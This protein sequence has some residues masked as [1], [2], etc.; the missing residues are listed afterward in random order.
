V[1]QAAPQLP[2]DAVSEIAK[3]SPL[4]GE[5]SHAFVERIW[6][7]F[8]S[9]RLTLGLLALLGLGL[10]LGHFV[11][12]AGDALP[13]LERAHA[14]RQFVLWTFR[15]FELYDVSRSWWFSLLWAALGLNFVASSLE[16]L[17]RIHHLL[18][19]PPLRLEEVPGLPLRSAE[20]KTQRTEAELRGALEK[21]GYAV[22]Q[23]ARDDGADLFAEKGRS[24]RWGLWVIHLAFLIAL[25][26]ALVNRF[27][28]FEGTAL[29][30]GN[31][32]RANSMVIR[33]RDGSELTRNL[34]LVVQCDDFRL[35]DATPGKPGASQSDLRLLSG[36]PGSEN[37][38]LAQKTISANDPLE[39]GGLTFQQATFEQLE[40]GSRAQVALV[41]KVTGRE[42][43][44]KLGAGESLEAAEGLTFRLVDYQE[45]FVGMGPAVQVMRVEE[46]PGALVNK[47]AGP[48]RVPSAQAKLSSFWIFANKPDFDRDNRTD[49]FALKFGKVAPLY[50]TGLRIS[51]DPS[52]P[53]LYAGGALLVAGLVLSFSTSHKRIWARLH[54]GRVAIG[55][56]AHR[57]QEAFSRELEKI[58]TAL[59]VEIE[60]KRPAPDGSTA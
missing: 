16:R 34:G 27:A 28:A 48:R 11:N 25:L 22:T 36:E 53:L 58:C 15:T 50:A 6:R 21:A 12:P 37:R 57:N 8:T 23:A 49:R 24:A 59:G 5:Q 1:T 42:Q 47:S 32:G 10:I 39:F 43:E 41:D 52:I 19:Y 29:V 44:M 3:A 2:P 30:P 38:V 26:G 9:L 4:T 33:G 14:G 18:K 45:D 17:P 35:K 7:L 40:Q 55:G 31:G 13:E 51:H 56:A 46:P 60:L 20:Q 54:A